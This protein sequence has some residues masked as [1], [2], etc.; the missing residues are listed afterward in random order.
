MQCYRCE[1]SVFVWKETCLAW[2]EGG[3]GDPGLGL[4]TVGRW[5]WLR[6]LG[7]RVSQESVVTE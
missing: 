6:V 4:I 5:R 2:A 7:L 1:P 3:N